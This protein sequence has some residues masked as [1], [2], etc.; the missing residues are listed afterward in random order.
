MTNKALATVALGLSLMTA[1]AAMFAQATDNKMTDSKM[2]DSMMTDNKM[3]DGAMS[4]GIAEEGGLGI[5][6]GDLRVHLGAR[7][8]NVIAAAIGQADLDPAQSR[9]CFAIEFFQKIAA[10]AAPGQGI[11]DCQGRVQ[12]QHQA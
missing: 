5:V 2:T 10:V 3:S 6:Q 1:P 8:R 9:A 12:S 4:D 7:H 11:A